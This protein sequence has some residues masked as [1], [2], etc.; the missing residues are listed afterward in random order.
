MLFIP[1]YKRGGKNPQS[2]SQLG[3]QSLPTQPHMLAPSQKFPLLVSS[4]SI[5]S[6]L[7]SSTQPSRIKT[8]VSTLLSL[9]VHLEPFLS[10]VL[11]VSFLSPDMGSA[12]PNLCV[13][14]CSLPY[15][16]T[17]QQLHMCTCVAMEI[18]ALLHQGKSHRSSRE[19]KHSSRFHSIHRR[20]L[21]CLALESCLTS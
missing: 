6:Q 2:S 14:Y 1:L 21:T 19:Y 7:S 18:L 16:P 9:P 5:R 11:D 17:P 15:K 12:P 13:H 10:Q 8:L 3:S 20:H 4:F